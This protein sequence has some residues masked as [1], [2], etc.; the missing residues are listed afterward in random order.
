MANPKIQSLRNKATHRVTI[1]DENLGEVEW[2]IRSIPA[3][4]LLQHYDIFQGLPE[5]IQMDP[6]NM[7]AEDIK[8]IKTMILP[9]MEVV[10]PVCVIDPPVTLD[11]NDPRLATDEVIHLRE[12][13]FGAIT[14]LFQE[15]MKVSG[16]TKE[17]EEARKKLQ[18]ASSPP[19]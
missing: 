4:D 18:G 9:M 6:D 1:Q 7:K 15:I 14:Q 12:I 2:V 16:M 19:Q 8:L 5:H 11:R 3:Y 17:A 10:V 13:G